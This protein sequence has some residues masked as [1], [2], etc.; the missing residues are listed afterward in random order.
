MGSGDMRT[1]GGQ[2][3][4]DALRIALSGGLLRLAASHNHLE[5]LAAGRHW[6][7]RKR[8]NHGRR[9]GGKVA[10]LQFCTQ[11]WARKRS[12]PR[13]YGYPH[14]LETKK[15]ELLLGRGIHLMKVTYSSFYD[16]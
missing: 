13:N 10:G 3:E 6:M 2:G 8:R 1:I 15:G 9:L 4:A 14:L 12:S 5:Y 11:A 7:G 16:K